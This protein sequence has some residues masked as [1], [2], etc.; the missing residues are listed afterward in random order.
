MIN[1]YP[2]ISFIYDRRKI[3]SP[4]KK[5]A[6]ELRINYA[7]KQK[8]LSTGVLL[9]PNQWKKGLIVNCPDSL[10]ISQTLD[11]LVTDVRQ[12]VLDMID[13]GNIDINQIPERIKQKQVEHISFI[14]YCK[15][16]AEVRKY[17]LD[18]DSQLRYD[19]FIK[20]FVEWGLITKFEDITDTN[21]ILY[22][23]YLSSQGLK[24]STIW[25]NYHRFLNSF[26]LDAIDDDLVSRNPYKWVN[27]ERRRIDSLEK[28]LTPQEFNRLKFSKMPTESLERV[29]DLFVFQTYTCLRYSDLARFNSNNIILIN[30]TEVYRCTQKKTKKGATIP[31]LKPALDILD[32]YRGVLPLIS[33]VKYNEYLKI[34]AQASGIDKPL[35]THWARHTGATILLN[36]GVDMKIVTKICGH[37]SMKITEQIY[38]KLLDE[39]VVK[40]IQD[41]EQSKSKT[42]K[43]RI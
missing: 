10:Q 27:I 39:T 33:N 8:F 12:I 22:D 15:V 18:P 1:K 28:C 6:V 41:L 24:R 31:L 29:R 38:A 7:G 17:G 35:S 36:E 13:K 40:A 5:A 16:R 2:Q 11:K 9:Y 34:V 30:G 32:K 25:N 20:F 43:S 14:E 21:I 26:I 23:K 37:S 19:R 3:A 42:R 4:Q